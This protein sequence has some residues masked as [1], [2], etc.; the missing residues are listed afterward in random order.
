[1]SNLQIQEEVDQS[2]REFSGSADVPVNIIYSLSFLE[3]NYYYTVNK[4][5]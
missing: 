1:M 5:L 2:W 4:Y 3:H